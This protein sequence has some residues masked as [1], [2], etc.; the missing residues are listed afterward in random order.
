MGVWVGVGDMVA[1][2]LWLGPGLGF[3]VRVEVRLSL[4]VGAG[5]VVGG[6]RWGIR[7]RQSP[8]QGWDLGLG[9]RAEVRIEMGVRGGGSS[10]GGVRVVVFRV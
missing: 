1:F 2:G 5:V 6:S 4:R 9:V 3:R 10:C 7:S 8:S